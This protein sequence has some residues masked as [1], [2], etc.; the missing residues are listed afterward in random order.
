MELLPGIHQ[1]PI[2]YHGRPLQLY[3]LSFGGQTML[4]DTGDADTPAK[5]ILPYFQKIGLD[6][7]QLTFVLLTH[8]DIDHVGGIHAMKAAAPQAKFFC[9]TADRAQIETPEG[10]GKIRAGAYLYWHGMGPDDAAMASFITHAGGPG[11]RLTIDRTFD[12]GE[13]L[14]LGDRDLH[15]LHVPGHSQGHLGVYLPWLNTAIIG[16]A[17]HHTANRNMDGSASFAPTY[18]WIDA[19]L[20]TIDQLQAMKLDCLFSCHWPNCMDN[21]AVNRFLDESRSYAVRAENAIFETVRAAG[22]EGLTL[23]EVCLRAKPALG[24]WPPERDSYTQSMACG[25]LQRLCDSGMLRVTE[26]RPARYIV[27]PVWRGLK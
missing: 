20:G 8:P 7:G 23:Q 14:R 12:G 27:E 17:V 21:A 26:D 11:K 10:L 4:I 25:H 2:V 15:V 19:Y 13:T 16:D 24:D 22:A 9:G 6:P 1:I 3:L 5:N 18:M